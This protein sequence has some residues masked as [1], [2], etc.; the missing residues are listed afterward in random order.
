MIGGEVSPPRAAPVDEPEPEP[1]RATLS[2]P[3]VRSIV[4]AFSTQAET[5]HSPREAEQAPQL[6]PVHQPDSVS[7]TPP[8]VARPVE[9]GD[10]WA[11]VLRAQN[12]PTVLRTLLTY[13]R[14]LSV[15]LAAG[16]IV[17]SGSS[18]HVESARGRHAQIVEVCRRELGR[19]VEVLIQSDEESTGGGAP[20]ADGAAE[21]AAAASDEDSGE[22]LRAPSEE[23]PRAAAPS[24]TPMMPSDHPL[25]K[26]AMELFGA[27][28]VDVQHRRPRA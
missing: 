12:V 1:A 10:A 25:V 19:A 7:K 13:L 15:D 24:S 23:T 16:R 22:E 9:S 11:R 18:R 17:L 5:P 8:T 4:E 2:A 27:R 21:Q 14:P 6:E 20:E 3:P 28:I 26:E